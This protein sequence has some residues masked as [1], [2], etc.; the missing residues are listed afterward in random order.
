MSKLTNLWE[1]ILAQ[2]PSHSRKALWSQMSRIIICENDVI[3]VGINSPAWLTSLSSDILMIKFI[4]EQMWRRSFEVK[5][6]PYIDFIDCAGGKNKSGFVY[7]I[8]DGREHKIGFTA[9]TTKS[10]LSE[11]K[12]HNPH[13][14]IVNEVYSLNGR[15]LEELFHDYF[16]DYRIYGEWFKFPEY[17]EI[18]KQFVSIADKLSKDV[19]L[20]SAVHTQDQ[21]R[22]N[23]SFDQY[24][25]KAIQQEKN[26]LTQATDSQ[27][28]QLN[29]TANFKEATYAKSVEKASK[30]LSDKLSDISIANHE[31]HKEI[32]DYVSDL[33]K[34]AKSLTK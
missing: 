4:A 12:G 6:V 32:R 9:R 22:S 17:M 19:V 31:A 13:A 3:Y 1:Q 24:A 8:F 26:N 33:I 30:K 2:A 29:A 28:N 15:K 16:K 25:T 10:R 23:M 18:E 27:L 21:T 5:L 34:I 11:I 7:L 20:P 14:R